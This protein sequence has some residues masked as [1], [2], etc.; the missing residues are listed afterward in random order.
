MRFPRSAEESG[1]GL[2]ACYRPASLV[3][4]EIEV[5][6]LS[7]SRAVPFWFKCDSVTFT[8]CV[9]TVLMQIHICSPCQLP[10]AYPV[11]DYQ[12]DSLLAI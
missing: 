7:T 2:G 6:S 4:Y 12:E 8:C 5:V 11:C 1:T 10:S 9:L 3:D